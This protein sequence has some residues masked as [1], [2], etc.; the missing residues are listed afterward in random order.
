MVLFLL[1]GL[2]PHAARKNIFM[3]WINGK[4]THRIIPAT[5]SFGIFDLLAQFL[6]GKVYQDGTFQSLRR[7]QI[8]SMTDRLCCLSTIWSILAI[9]VT[10]CVLCSMCSIFRD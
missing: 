10:A 8:S 2:P 3:S 7:S 4:I 6:M 5:L 1:T 9:S